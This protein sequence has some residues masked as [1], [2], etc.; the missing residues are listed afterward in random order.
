MTCDELFKGIE[1]KVGSGI[2]FQVVLSMLEIYNEQVGNRRERDEKAW[3][4]TP[5]IFSLCTYV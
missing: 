4:F 3:H 2:E 1:E 5:A